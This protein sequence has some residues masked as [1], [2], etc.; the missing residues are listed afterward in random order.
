MLAAVMIICTVA[1]MFVSGGPGNP[2]QYVSGGSDQIKM[3]LSQWFSSGRLW[4]G[5]GFCIMVAAVVITAAGK[6]QPAA[7]T[8]SPRAID[9][10]QATT[11]IGQVISVCRPPAEIKRQL[12]LAIACHER[13]AG[14]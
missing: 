13:P 9:R 11:G 14:R 1:G 4:I 6:R 5:T 8:Q 10:S 2:G 3:S 12:A 7:A